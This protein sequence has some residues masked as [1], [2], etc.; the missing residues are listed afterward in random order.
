PCVLGRRLQEVHDLSEFGLG[1]ID[2]GDILEGDLR[3]RFSIEATCSA[4]SES[5]E[6]AAH[7]HSPQPAGLLGRSPEEPHIDADYEDGRSEAEQE[8]D[9]WIATFLDRLSADLD[10][11]RDEQ[12][13]ETRIDE[14]W[15]CC[16]K[17]G[18]GSRLG[19]TR[20]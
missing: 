10:S 4:L 14:R 20:C 5:G 1:L 8:G 13:L 16:V 18:G 15:K 12:R 11:V 17:R 9:P 7:S 2:S 3:I 19:A 6:R